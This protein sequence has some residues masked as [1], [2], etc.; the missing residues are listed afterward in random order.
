MYSKENNQQ[1]KKATCEMGENIYEA[2]I[3]QAF[4]SKINKK[5]TTQQ[6]KT[7]IIII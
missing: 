2:Y 6:Q 7:T 3:W 5:H 4:I 1:N